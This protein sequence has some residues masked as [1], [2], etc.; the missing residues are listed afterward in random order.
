MK[1]ARSLDGGAD[2]RR[3]SIAVGT[4]ARR[5]CGGLCVPRLTHD[6]KGITGTILTVDAGSMLRVP[7]RSQQ[8]R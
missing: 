8:N 3:Q 7:P 1:F 2:T 4:A 6:P 5:S